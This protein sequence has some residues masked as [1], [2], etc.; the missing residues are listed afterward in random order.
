MDVVEEMVKDPAVGMAWLT[1][2]YWEHLA[3]KGS[4]RRRERKMDAG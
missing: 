1:L 3:W 4:G 2:V